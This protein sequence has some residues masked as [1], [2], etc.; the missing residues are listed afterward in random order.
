MISTTQA[1][2]LLPL[3]TAMGKFPRRLRSARA[4]GARHRL[5]I[6]DVD[7]TL[8]DTRAATTHT[9]QRTFEQVG[10]PQPAADG[11]AKTVA[12]GIG[13]DDTFIQLVPL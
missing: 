5:V 6:F 13:L 12:M 7:G 9:V 4:R 8:F 1:K 11:I 10:L 3:A 2:S